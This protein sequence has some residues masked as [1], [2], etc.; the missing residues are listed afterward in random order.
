MFVCCREG[1]EGVWYYSTEAQLEELLQTLD[2]ERWEEE[3]VKNIE[4]MKEEILRQMTVTEQLTAENKSGRR[5]MLDIE[6]GACA[7]LS[8]KLEHDV[9][10]RLMVT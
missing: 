5:S 2:K 9:H 6:N 7:K 1:D 10:K 8:T 4:D 3:L